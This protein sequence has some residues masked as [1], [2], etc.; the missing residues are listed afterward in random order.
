MLYN[1]MKG[2]V[3]TPQFAEFARVLAFPMNSALLGGPAAELYC[4]G[5]KRDFASS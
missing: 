5:N 3:A 4:W 2:T 1:L